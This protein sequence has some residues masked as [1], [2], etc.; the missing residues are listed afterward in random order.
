MLRPDGP[1]GA[2]SASSTMRGSSPPT[3]LITGASGSAALRSAPPAPLTRLFRLARLSSSTSLSIFLP[4][5]IRPFVA[6]PRLPQ[7]CRRLQVAGQPRDRAVAATFVH[8]FRDEPSPILRQLRLRLRAH[9]Q[10]Q[11]RKERKQTS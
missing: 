1:R 9:R 6:A 4:L 10:K 5:I 8:A 2:A 3:I 11:P 7:C